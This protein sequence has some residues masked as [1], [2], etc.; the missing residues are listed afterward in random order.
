MNPIMELPSRRGFCDV[1][2]LPRRDIDKLALVVKLKW[3]KSAEGAIQQIKDRQYTEWLDEYTE[4]VL[5]VGINYDTKC[6]VHKCIIE[7]I[8]WCNGGSQFIP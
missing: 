5:L 4:N 3:N 8:S 1:V 2:Y 7:A 6:K